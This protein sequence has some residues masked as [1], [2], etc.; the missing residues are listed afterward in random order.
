M[1]VTARLTAPEKQARAKGRKLTAL[2]TV[3][4]LCSKRTAT[5]TIDW[6]LLPTICIVTI[7]SAKGAACEILKLC[8]VMECKRTI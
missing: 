8:E 2:L 6:L 1:N 5:Q 4:I 7:S 3:S